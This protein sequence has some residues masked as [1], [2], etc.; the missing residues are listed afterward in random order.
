MNAIVDIKGLTDMDTITI[1]REDL[2]QLVS[3]NQC[4]AQTINELSVLFGVIS[5][6]TENH[7]NAYVLAMIGQKMANDWD[8]A[9]ANEVHLIRQLEAAIAETYQK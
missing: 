5:E 3:F 8:D 4:F 2:M 9:C 1:S 6:K 7:T